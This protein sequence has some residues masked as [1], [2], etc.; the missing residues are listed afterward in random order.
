[1]CS[2]RQEPPE[3]Y[4][5]VDKEAGGDMWPTFS[6]G[7]AICWLDGEGASPSPLRSGAKQKPAGCSARQEPPEARKDWR[8]TGGKV[9]GTAEIT[10]P[11][12]EAGETGQ[13]GEAKEGSFA[14]SAS[15]GL[16]LILTRILLALELL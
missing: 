16:Q 6:S 4:F 1:M 9:L 7:S 14:P 10:R 3:G 8:A 12:F 5:E 15:H 13:E 11:P 2:A